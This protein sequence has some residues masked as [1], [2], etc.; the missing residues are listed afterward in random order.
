MRY[1]ACRLYRTYVAVGGGLFMTIIDSCEGDCRSTDL[2]T[3]AARRNLV[4]PAL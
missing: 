3:V 2:R 4:Q 1:R